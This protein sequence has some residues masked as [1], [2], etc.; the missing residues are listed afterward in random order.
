MLLFGLR[1]CFSIHPVVVSF[2]FL[3]VIPPGSEDLPPKSMGIRLQIRCVSSQI[4]PIVEDVMTIMFSVYRSF[5]S[6]QQ[7]T[8]GW[9][10]GEVK[11]VSTSSDTRKSLYVVPEP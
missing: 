7:I 5:L 9:E 11:L 1:D 2:G 4:S 3:V 10:K 8:S 6:R